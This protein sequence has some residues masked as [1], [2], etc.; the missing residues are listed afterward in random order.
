MS[1]R[2]AQK[3]EAAYAYP[4]LIKQLLHTPLATARRAASLSGKQTMREA[5]RVIR[6]AV[7]RCAA[8]P[9]EIDDLAMGCV[10]TAGTQGSNSESPPCP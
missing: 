6:D 8:D 1:V 2:L 3:A 9:A 7:S 5:V 10:L 4:L